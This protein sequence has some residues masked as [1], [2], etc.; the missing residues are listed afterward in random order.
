M[1]MI[2]LFVL[3]NL[4]CALIPDRKPD[5]PLEFVQKSFEGKPVDLIYPG[6]DRKDLD[7]LLKESWTRTYGYE[8]YTQFRERP[9]TGRYVNVSAEG[10]RMSKNQ[11]PWPPSPDH[12]NV[13]V[14]GGSAVFG[15]GVSDEQTTVSCL[16]DELASL[17]DGHKDIR[18]YNFGR[19]NYYSTQ[20][21]I[22]FS[23]LLIEGFVPDMA[24]FIDGAVDL[25]HPDDRPALSHHFEFLFNQLEPNMSIPRHWF[26]F[27]SWLASLPSVRILRD[28]SKR[29]GKS[30]TEHQENQMERSDHNSDALII[31][32]VLNRY[33]QNKKSIEALA[34]AYHVRTAFVWQPCPLY[35]YDLS[36][37]LFGDAFLKN[38]N[39]MLAVDGYPC[40]RKR[41]EKGALGDNFLW[42]ADIQENVK[43]P[44]YVDKVHYTADMSSRLAKEIAQ[45][46][47][48]RNLLPPMKA[49]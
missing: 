20:E 41:M 44:L 43:Q 34:K 8:P 45:Q 29:L 15:L 30:Q 46:M 9:F 25:N 42:C 11:A 49:N 2:V 23:R 14:F 21:R 17:T 47:Q 22:L 1:N 13:F 16:Q 4:I 18:V 32:K 19:G 33:M 5:S 12:Y 26:S 6:V 35:K 3:I 48:T 28:L 39:K 38:G 37:H 31:E 27:K 7:L 36:Y 40:M 10:F 24:L